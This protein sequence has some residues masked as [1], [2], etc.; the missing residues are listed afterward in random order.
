MFNPQSVEAVDWTYFHEL[1]SWTILFKFVYLFSWAVH[2]LLYNGWR[3]NYYIT[4]FMIDF[5]CSILL[6]YFHDLPASFCSPR[7][8]DTSQWSLQAHELKFLRMAWRSTE[9]LAVESGNPGSAGQGRWSDQWAKHQ[10]LRIRSM[11]WE[12]SWGHQKVHHS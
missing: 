2:E 3:S 5:L 8:A 11:N 6:K 10:I 4:I 7:L 9:S 1:C 12:I